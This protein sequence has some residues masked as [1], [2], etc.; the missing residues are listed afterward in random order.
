MKMSR[1]GSRSGS[2]RK[3]YN[4]SEREKKRLL[5]TA[6][7]IQKSIGRSIADILLEL[8]YYSKTEQ[9]KLAAIRLFYDVVA[10]KESHQTVEKHDFGPVIGLPPMKEKPKDPNF[11]IPVEK[12]N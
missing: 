10:V 2:G 3:S 1:G 11:F 8:I 12:K 5:S 6:R 7:K 9:T 4:L